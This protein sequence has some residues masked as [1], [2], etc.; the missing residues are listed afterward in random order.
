MHPQKIRKKIAFSK[1][2]A[3]LLTDRP[4]DGS[5]SNRVIHGQAP[6]NS[7]TRPRELQTR[8]RK[9]RTNF[10]GKTI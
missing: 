8:P 10:D 2:M 5:F 9:S 1:I 4:M 6:H 7:Q 3:L